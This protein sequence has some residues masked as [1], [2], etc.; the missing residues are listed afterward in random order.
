MRCCLNILMIRFLFNG[1]N[2]NLERF[3]VAQDKWDDYQSALAEMKAG[4]KVSHWIWYIF[5]QIK[6]LG[7]SFTS[8]RYAIDSLYEAQCYLQDELLGARL[9]EITAA[10]LEHRRTPIAQIMGGSLDAMKFRS[11]M[12]LFD[13]VS[14]VD[15]FADALQVFFAGERAPQTL[16]IV[17][18]RA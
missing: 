11:S 5:P 10:V 15:I 14:P 1:M 3:R 4:R 9:R 7:E 16:K 12:T 18:G 8:Q 6:G 17:N 2:M 13:L